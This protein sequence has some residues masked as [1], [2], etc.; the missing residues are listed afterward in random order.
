MLRVEA[1]K[2]KEKKKNSDREL[3]QGSLPFQAEKQES[4]V[5]GIPEN[6]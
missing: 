4:S 1:S 3:M 6:R 2:V 5:V